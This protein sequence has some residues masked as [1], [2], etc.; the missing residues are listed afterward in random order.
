[1]N[2]FLE[3][4]AFVTRRQFFGRSA[5]GLGTAARQERGRPA[6]RFVAWFLVRAGEPPALLSLQ[7]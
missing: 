7:P 2:P 4:Q 3:R 5:M 1:M 6:R